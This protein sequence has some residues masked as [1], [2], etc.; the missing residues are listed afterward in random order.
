MA[1]Q[2]QIILQLLLAAVLGGLVGVERE[3]QKRA[4][5]LRTY[6][7]V[8]LSAALFTIISSEAFTAFAGTTGIVFD[9]SRIIAGIVL[10]VGFIGAGLILP[11]G[12]KIDGITTATGI[13]L[14]SAI[15]V[16]V[17]I[18]LYLIAAFT[19]FLALG[20]LTIF[21]VVEEKFLKIDENKKS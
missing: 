20:I 16:A 14:V 4:A 1:I 9:P 10:G 15:G 3:Y 2:I 17:G 6:S 7:L 19:A 13:W 12:S 5:G 8:C 18:K 11:H 21:R